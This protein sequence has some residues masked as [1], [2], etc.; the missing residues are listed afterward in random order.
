MSEFIIKFLTVIISFL[1][2]RQIGKDEQKLT[3]DERV[4]QD[5]QEHAKIVSNVS[6]MS[7]TDIGAE[8]RKW[9]ECDKRHLLN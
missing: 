8:L 7:D 1:S 4:L 6:A 2:A 5:V 3:D 9:K